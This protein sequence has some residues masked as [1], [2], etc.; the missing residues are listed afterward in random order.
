M[1]QVVLKTSG[2][3]NSRRHFVPL[4]AIYCPLSL[5]RR[6]CGRH[7]SLPMRI[8]RIKELVL[9]QPRSSTEGHSLSTRLGSAWL[10]GVRKQTQATS[11]R[12]NLWVEDWMPGD[13]QP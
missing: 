7:L 10:S 4:S 8:S 2:G 5:L 1:D 13:Q 12:L 9:K 3:Q 11:F 6:S